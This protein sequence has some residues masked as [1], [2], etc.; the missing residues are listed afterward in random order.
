MLYISEVRTSKSRRIFGKV[1][2]F[3]SVSRFAPRIGLLRQDGSPVRAP[4]LEV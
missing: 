2:S 1:G 4:I 3:A